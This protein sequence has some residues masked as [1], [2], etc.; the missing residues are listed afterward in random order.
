VS[1][2]TRSIPLAQPGVSPPASRGLANTLRQWSMGAATFMLLMPV[3]L[4]PFR[5]L[6]T[7]RVTCLG[8]TPREPEVAVD[9]RSVH[10]AGRVL[11]VPLDDFPAERARAIAASFRDRFGTPVD[12]HT[13]LVT[14][15]GLIDNWKGQ[16]NADAVLALLDQRYP[17]SENREVVIALTASDMYI[18]WSGWRY[19]FSYRG[20]ARL[21]V[22][23]S[24]RMDHGCMGLLPAAPDTQ[25]ARLRKMVG[26]NIGVLYYGLPLSH[27]PRSLVYASVGG[28]QELDVMSES[29]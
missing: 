22:V 16:L 27:D 23:S 25:L 8:V 28:P 18:P 10:P 15:S 9:V 12:V 6:V 20:R 26:K 19:A 4:L 7:D 2:V 21:A 3:A 13:S 14:P 29:F 17:R 1:E 11:L 5:A 24:M